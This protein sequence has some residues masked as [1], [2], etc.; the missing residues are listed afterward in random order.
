MQNM[1]RCFQRAEKVSAWSDANQL[2]HH[3]SIE[4]LIM[5]QKSGDGKSI[6]TVINLTPVLTNQI[7]DI[8]A[9]NGY[10]SPETGYRSDKT[11]RRSHRLARH[12]R[13]NRH[14]IDLDE[15]EPQLSKMRHE[16]RMMNRV[17]V[18]VLIQRLNSL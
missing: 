6:T 7:G 2:S 10:R 12:R 9:G 1:E 3:V 4:L 5:S 8:Q 15:I 13:Q 16:L 14:S 17:K 11:D 18:R